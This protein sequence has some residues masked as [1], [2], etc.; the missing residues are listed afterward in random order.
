VRACNFPEQFTSVKLGVQKVDRRTGGAEQHHGVKST[1]ERLDTEKLVSLNNATYAALERVE[2]SRRTAKWNGGPGFGTF[3]SEIQELCTC[4]AKFGEYALRGAARSAANHTR[5][6]PAHSPTE[7]EDLDYFEVT[8]KRAGNAAVKL[9]GERMAAAEVYELVLIDDEVMGTTL[10]PSTASDAHNIARKEQR[11]KYIQDLQRRGGPCT[12]RLHMFHP[13]GPHP[14]VRYAWRLPA[15]EAD[16]DEVAEAAAVAKASAAAPV[17]ASRA[18]RRGF[19]ERYSPTGVSPALLK[20][21]HQFLTGDSAAPHDLMDKVGLKCTH[22]L[23][24]APSPPSASPLP[25]GPRARHHLDELR[26]RR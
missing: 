8:A 21:M 2:A 13:G 18:I 26:L 11:R 22:T 4:L 3:L 5:T 12:M 19:F 6:G 15:D 25:G 14:S 17:T 7:P 20:S 1:R 9:L 23:P 16:R 24:R 10:D